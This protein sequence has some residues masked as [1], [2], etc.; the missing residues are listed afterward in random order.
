MFCI[1]I[2]HHEIFVHHIYIAKTKHFVIHS[3]LGQNNFNLSYDP[4]KDSVFW[5]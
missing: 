2:Y 4:T 3:H 5:C 1:K